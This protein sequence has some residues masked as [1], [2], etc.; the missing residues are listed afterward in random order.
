MDDQSLENGLPTAV[1]QNR[2]RAATLQNSL[3]A[4][5][6][7]ICQRLK[8][9]QKFAPSFIL[10][11]EGLRPENQAGR[12]MDK[13]LQNHG[14]ESNRF[15]SLAA[16]EILVNVQAETGRSVEIKELRRGR[17]PRCTELDGEVMPPPSTQFTK[18]RIQIRPLAR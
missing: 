10:E 4:A 12:A 1:V 8:D 11:K 5:T 7:E 14:L 17:K 15:F 18:I 13:I 3:R 16:L 6:Q 9:Q 2:S